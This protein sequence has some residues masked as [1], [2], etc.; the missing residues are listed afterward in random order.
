MSPSG[1]G[2]GAPRLAGGGH[3]DRRRLEAQSRLW[4]PFTFRT[5]AA[6][7]VGPGWHCLEVGAGTGTVA[8][9]LVDR[10]GPGGRVVATD[11]ETRWLAPLATT[12]LEVRHHD[13]ADH[14]LEADGY[15]LIHLRLV[16][17]HLPQREAVAGK[18]VRALRPGGWLVVEDYDL[19]TIAFTDP[20]SRAW[21][22]V[23]RAVLGVF[24]AAGSD[25]VCGSRLLR[26]LQSA[27]LTDVV[28]EGC[29]R[30][31]DVR[32]LAPVF[33]TALAALADQLAD[34]DADAVTA[35]ALAEV[36]ADFDRT[37]DPP[38][39]YTP[40]LVAATGRRPP[41]AGRTPAPGP[42]DPAAPGAAA[43]RTPADVPAGRG[44][45]RDC[46]TST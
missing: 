42:N 4:D 7:G 23:N 40:I 10:V 37:P 16:L 31:M 22:E 41:V 24:A 35:A 27:G 17:E 21:Q 25:G 36:L 34:A 3:S 44:G 13:V 8:T 28:A 43:R 1:A 18:L 32:A 11:I 2:R 5:L 12:N 33:R 19:R 46:G 15:D 29:V 20:P 38:A 39:A 26:M 9:W 45:P 30:S 6:T 14:P